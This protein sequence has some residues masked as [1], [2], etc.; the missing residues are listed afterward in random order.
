MIAV[1]AAMAFSSC[2]NEEAGVSETRGPELVF[3]LAPRAGLTRADDGR[4]IYSSQALQYVEDMKVYAFKKNASDE[5][6]YTQVSDINGNM[7]D[8]Y[9]IPWTKG[10]AEHE[11]KITPKLNAGDVYKFLAVG[12]DSGK[13]N[14]AAL[15]LTGKKLE[16]VLL[17]VAAGGK[18]REAFAGVSAEMTVPDANT[19]MKA[20]ITLT[21]VVAGVMGYFKNIPAAV[22]GVAV[23][24]VAVVLYTTPNNVVNLT[25][26]AGSNN[27]SALSQTLIE[28]T[29]PAGAGTDANGYYTFTQ[30]LPV[31]IA[32]LENSLIGGVYAMPVAAPG[33]GTHTLKVEV[34]DAAGNILKEWNVKIDAQQTGDTDA[35]KR[36]YSLIANHFYSIGK[37]V[38]DTSTTDPTTPDE[39][40]D[41]SKNQD[42]VV[43]VNPDWETVHNMELE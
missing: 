31:G 9:V 2:S 22:G 41:L 33:S 13:A 8:A 3:S 7:L 42:L 5:F 38:S 4:D 39:P 37:K 11:Y 43:T 19:Q 23:N 20:D 40:A 26:K 35:T 1:A 25:T 30:T 17:A 16:E 14:F 24:K 28:L 34:Q 12:L 32:T 15:D 36:L 10:D 18:T 29:V 6:V 21:R 27:S